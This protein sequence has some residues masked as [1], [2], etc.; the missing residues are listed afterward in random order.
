M[1]A[2]MIWKCYKCD[3]YFVCNGSCTL[4]DYK[5]CL[6]NE[7]TS[8]GNRCLEIL[9]EANNKEIIADKL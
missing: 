9:R 2:N 7:C 8:K 6:C 3:K 4:D 1:K 5:E